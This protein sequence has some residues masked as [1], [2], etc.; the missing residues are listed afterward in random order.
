VA[1]LANE[2]DSRRNTSPLITLPQSNSASLLALGSRDANIHS[3]A[4]SRTEYEEIDLLEG[5]ENLVVPTKTYLW[6]NHL[7]SGAKKVLTLSVY[8][9]SDFNRIHTPYD[10]LFNRDAYVQNRGGFGA[11]ASLI[12][13][14]ER[15]NLETGI[16]YSAKNYSPEQ[17][18]E[19]FSPNEFKAYKAV[20]LEGIDLNIVSVPLNVLYRFDNTG[21]WR[22][23]TLAGISGQLAV[24]AEYDTERK[25]LAFPS[26]YLR[27]S[28][29]EYVNQGNRSLLESKDFNQGLLD[30]GALKDN[31]FITLNA[32]IGVEY[33]ISEKMRLFAQPQYQFNFFNTGL[34]PND[35]RIDIFSFQLGTRFDLNR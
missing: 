17:V 16:Q 9:N 13:G 1:G 20:S 4:V 25:E 21:K 18:V 7:E 6:L 23:Y 3:M 24:K 10:K 27:E 35:D 29:S 34:G 14:G 8:V 12:I 33:L 26:P 11:G 15:M 2:I 22:F 31:L 30:G 5:R 28:E 19:L 32:G